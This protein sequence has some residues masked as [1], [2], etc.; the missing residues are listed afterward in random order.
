MAIVW[1]VGGIVSMDLVGV[2]WVLGIIVCIVLGMLWMRCIVVSI[3]LHMLRRMVHIL[4][5]A[6]VVGWDS[7]DW[8]MVLSRNLNISVDWL[9]YSI[10]MVWNIN[11]MVNSVGVGVCQRLNVRHGQI[12]SHLVLVFNP[13][14]LVIVGNGVDGVGGG[15]MH[16]TAMVW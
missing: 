2:V 16:I 15:L 1:N 7:H 14:L 6:I 5:V 3:V 10:V 12:G 9:L 13:V 4:E 8:F 11:G